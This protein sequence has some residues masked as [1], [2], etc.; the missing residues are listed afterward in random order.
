[1]NGKD[2]TSIFSL[3]FKEWKDNFGGYDFVRTPFYKSPMK[4]AIAQ[5][6]GFEDIRFAEDHKFAIKVY[7]LLKSEYFIN[8]I[9]YYYQPVFKV[10]ENRYSK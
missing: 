7:P 1:M 2:K 6:I 5:Q 3:M 4:T 8:K 10:G 9:L